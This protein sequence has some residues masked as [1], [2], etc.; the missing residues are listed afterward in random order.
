MNISKQPLI[1][2]LKR[3]EIL[4]RKHEVRD[5]QMS[6]SYMELLNEM[7]NNSPWCIERWLKSYCKSLPTHANDAFYRYVGK[8]IP[9]EDKKLQTTLMEKRVE[10]IRRQMHEIRQAWKENPSDGQQRH[11]ILIDELF[12]QSRTAQP[13]PAGMITLIVDN[14]AAYC[15]SR[16]CIGL[17][18]FRTMFSSLSMSFQL[19]E[20]LDLFD[21]MLVMHFGSL[22]TFDE[23]EDESEFPGAFLLRDGSEYGTVSGEA[24]HCLR[25][26][27]EI[28][29]RAA[30]SLGDVNRLI[31]IATN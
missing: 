14:W 8:R 2:R 19:A 9:R 21:R 5:V 20:V 30:V 15:N 7:V 28:C 22:M 6:K 4:A 11:T 27:A 25:D 26:I 24:V 12:P 13:L 16:T 10:Y 29:V 31:N 1:Q 18:T 23:D 3:L 17:A